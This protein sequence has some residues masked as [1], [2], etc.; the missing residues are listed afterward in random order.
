MT[1]IITI[2]RSCSMKIFCKFPTSNMH[3]EELNLKRACVRVCVCVCV[4]ER[5][6][7]RE[8]CVCVCVSE[9]ERVCVCL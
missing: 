9:Y 2:L 6:C 7:V 3:S 1:K 8:F 4:R 5:E